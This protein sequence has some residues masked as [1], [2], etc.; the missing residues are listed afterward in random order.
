MNSIAEIKRLIKD[1]EPHLGLNN[2]RLINYNLIFNPCVTD[3]YLKELELAYD[4]KLPE[5]YREYLI[6][7]GNGGNQ[8]ADGML[9]AKQSLSILYG[10]DCEKK[11]K[12][13]IR[14]LQSIILA[15]TGLVM[16]ICWTFTMEVLERI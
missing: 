13:I 15:L 12:S 14:I 4:V 7:I 9:T 8:P 1:V 5:E 10:Q 2:T 6:N 16:I 3:S 11:A